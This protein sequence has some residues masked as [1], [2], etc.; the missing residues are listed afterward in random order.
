MK[1]WQRTWVLAFVAGLALA[2]CGKARDDDD[3]KKPAAP[4][5]E[6]AADD[7]ESGL[8]L[9]KADQERAGIRVTE[10]AERSV[11]AEAVAYGRLEEDP[12]FGFVARAPYAGILRASG[13]WPGLGQTI[14]A[15]TLLGSVEPRLGLAERVGLNNQLASARADLAAATEAGKAAQAAYNRAAAL[16]ADNKNVSDR[17]LEEAL[18][19][20]TA[21]KTRAAGARAL[22]ASLEGSMSSTD[23]RPVRIERGGE[24]VE[25]SAQP[26]ESL[27]P[28]AAILRV[29]QLDHLL[30]RVE[31]PAGDKGPSGASVRLVT[32]TGETLTGER[33]SSAA[34]PTGAA[35][36]YRVQ[37]AGLK[38][39][40]AVS[41]WY[42]T[43]G[44]AKKALVVPKT[45][46][47]Q[48]DGR[49]WVYVQT[50][51]ERFA[52]RAISLDLPAGDGYAVTRGFEPGEKVVT[53]G[54][55]TLLSEEFKSRNEVDTN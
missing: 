38:P 22:I 52:R 14:P 50:A 29:V 19:R 16:N 3:D 12:S 40:L 45:A 55:Q 51:D 21:E 20:L 4:A 43:G 35:I 1:S 33:A 46:V 23:A 44:A 36:L 10:L 26:G 30:A 53:T 32:A 5:A 54:A 11:T 13:N 15:G 8:K 2:G 18:A 39:G 17:V 25:V 37:K 34:T 6:K 24:V 7:D 9:K 48:Q 47:V 31:I 49:T 42:P 27:E 28:G 41:A